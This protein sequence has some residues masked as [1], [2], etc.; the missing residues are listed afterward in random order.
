[1]NKKILI[2]NGPNLNLLGRREAT[3]YGEKSFEEYL[4]HLKEKFSSIDL[5][6]FQS[7][8]ESAIIDALHASINSC[9]GVIINAGAYSHTSIAIY[10][11]IR[12]IS[13]PCIEVHISNIY[14]R[15]HFRSHTLMSSVCKGSISGFGL[16]SYELA[17]HYF[18]IEKSFV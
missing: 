12:A 10:D 11:A 17:I 2:I 5:E 18:L 15:E 8:S 6:F 4:S 13:I 16:N 14:A 1:M 3:I 7:N 9:M